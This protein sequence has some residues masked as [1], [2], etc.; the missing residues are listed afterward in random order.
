MTILA[1]AILVIPIGISAFQQQQAYAPRTCPGCGPFLELTSQFE[2][3]V[4]Q[5]IREFAV[6]NHPNNVQAYAEF[7]KFT[8]QF[9]TDVLNAVL[10]NPPEPNKIPEL[11]KVY[12]DGT[13][14]IF[15]G[16]PD[17]IPVL[18]QD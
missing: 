13:L 16:G 15:L 8:G 17:T 10:S 5:Y 9:K 7:K 12:T 1:A 2:R 11:H 3:D 18:L 14:S 6:E 4:G